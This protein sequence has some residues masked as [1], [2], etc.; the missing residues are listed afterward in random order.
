MYTLKK[1]GLFLLGF[2]PSGHKETV[3]DG[4]M[5]DVPVCLWGDW[6]NGFKEIEYKEVAVRIA[7]IVGATV[8]E[9]QEK[10]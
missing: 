8:I 10:G 5:A 2:Q 7:K 3:Y 4:T 9:I 1:D 6:N